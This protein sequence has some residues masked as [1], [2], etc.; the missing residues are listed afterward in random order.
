[1]KRKKKIG[2]QKYE[3]VIEDQLTSPFLQD[4]LASLQPEIT[5]EEE[6]EYQSIMRDLQESGQEVQFVDSST[7]MNLSEQ[8][9][10]EV[11]MLTNFDCW[12]GHTNFNLSK[13]IVSELER[14]EGIELLR[15]CSRYRFFIGIGKMFDFKAVRKNLE[16]RLL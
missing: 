12:V 5:Q 6:Q 9:I 7:Q 15:I 1:M 10:N 4:M 13:K 14:I 8:F 3:S 11:S 2:W 16:K